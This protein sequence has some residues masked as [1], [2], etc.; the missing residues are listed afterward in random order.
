M[1]L[2]GPDGYPQFRCIA[3]RCRHSCCVGWEID[4]DRPTMERYRGIPG[5]LGT[6]LRKW[7]QVTEEGACFRLTEQ[8]KCPF[9]NEDG[10]C[11]LILEL[12]EGMLCQICADH[13]RFRNGFSDRTEIGLGLCCEAA[14]RLI[15]NWREPMQLVVLGEDEAEENA[16]W[17]EE[18]ELLSLRTELIK[19]A[20]N[21]EKPVEIRAEEVLTRASASFPKKSM[22]WWAKELLALERLDAGWANWLEQLTKSSEEQL[23][24][25]EILE[26]PLEQLLV[27][28][29]YRHLPGALEDGG[30]SERIAFAVL[31]WRLVRALYGL[32][33]ERMEGE[34]TEALIEAARMY[35]SEIEYSD[36]NMEKILE[37]IRQEWRRPV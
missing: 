35:S 27:Y 20:Q 31:S 33:L 15:L 9:L 19:I 32:V 13:P 3:D 17:P 10:L 12:G 26:I 18:E 8:G 4:I 28:F 2:I 11:A 36:E 6:Q 24:I 16:L 22:A 37:L 1:R 14:G 7:T 34:E 23:N 30:L 25:P 21:R 5:E 29:L